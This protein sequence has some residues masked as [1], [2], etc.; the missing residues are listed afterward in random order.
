MMLAGIIGGVLLYGSR[1]SRLVP[2]C[3]RWPSFLLALTIMAAVDGGAHRQTAGGNFLAGLHRLPLVLMLMALLPP[4][5]EVEKAREVDFVSSL[6]ILLLTVLMLG[7]LAAMLLLGS[8]YIEA[9]L[10]TCW[11][12]FDA[13]AAGPRIE[14]TDRVCRHRQHDLPLHDVD[15]PAH[16]AVVA[17]FVQPRP[18]RGRSARPP[19]N[20]LAVEIAQRLP[21]VRGGEWIAGRSSAAS[22]ASWKAA[23]RVQP[24][25]HEKLVFY[26]PH[27]LADADLALQPA[28]RSCRRSSTP[29]SSVRS[30]SKA[31]VLSAGHP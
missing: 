22:L 24:W 15:R 16:G 3:S 8:G 7:S 20:R 6:L 19:G 21:W 27:L 11:S 28:G 2:T 29:T 26:T 13:P 9:M 12:R 5:Q 30:N 14:S 31:I 25:R 23:V 4:G 17:G 18:A 10:Q 1:A